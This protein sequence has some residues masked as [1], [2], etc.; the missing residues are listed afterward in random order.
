MLP[1]FKPLPKVHDG[2]LVPPRKGR[3]PDLVGC[4]AE[5]AI[6]L[7]RC[8]CTHAQLRVALVIIQRKLAGG[9]SGVPTARS[10]QRVSVTGAGEDVSDGVGGAMLQTSR[11]W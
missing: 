1:A 10:P 5:I 3:T 11:L 8:L 9:R 6:G 2:T 4:V 7:V